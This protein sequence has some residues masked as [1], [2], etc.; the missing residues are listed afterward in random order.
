MKAILSAYGRDRLNKTR[1]TSMPPKDV[2]S[3]SPRARNGMAGFELKV[4]R[5]SAT[6]TIGRQNDGVIIE[7]DEVPLDKERT[8]SRGTICVNVSPPKLSNTSLTSNTKDFDKIKELEVR[9]VLRLSPKEYNSS[10]YNPIYYE[11]I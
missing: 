7:K 11:I 4:L 6:S 9:F 8:N 10:V 5:E 1:K 2:A 3:S